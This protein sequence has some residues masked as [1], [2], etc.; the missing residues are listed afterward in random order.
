VL[1]STKWVK[2]GYSTA[3]HNPTQP[4]R[5]NQ[6]GPLQPYPP[7]AL[8]S[9]SPWVEQRHHKILV[10][11]LPYTICRPR[12][13]GLVLAVIG[14]LAWGGKVRGIKKKRDGSALALGGHR[15]KC[16]NNKQMADGVNIRGCVGE[17]A[18]LG[19]NVWGGR[20]PVIWRVE[21]INKKIERWADPWP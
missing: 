19:W 5:N 7:A 2:L 12:A 13:V 11:P 15:F 4:H 1:Y 3:S 17:E 14:F 16:I 10:P 21:L 9:L 8:P 20:R 18:R 6:H